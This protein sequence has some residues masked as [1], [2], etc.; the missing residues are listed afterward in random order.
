MCVCV[1]WWVSHLITE[2]RVSVNQSQDVTVDAAAWW[3]LGKDGRLH[4]LLPLPDDHLTGLPLTHHLLVTLADLCIYLWKSDA[5]R[6]NVKKTKETVHECVCVC[7]V[8]DSC[9]S[10]PCQTC[11]G[12]AGKATPPS[13]CR[14][15][16][17]R[18]TPAAAAPTPCSST[19]T[20]TH[21]NTKEVQE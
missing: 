3:E 4:L 11:S 6:H 10:C 2:C 19:D 7:V 16:L 14:A 1:G 21:T 13:W 5:A 20:H 12:P 17:L 8:P 18:N 15:A 9:P